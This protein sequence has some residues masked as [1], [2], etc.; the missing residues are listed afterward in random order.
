[1][2]NKLNTCKFYR[3]IKMENRSTTIIFLSL[4]LATL[5]MLGCS[6][7]KEQLG[8][9]KAAPDEFKV[10]RRAPLAMPPDYSLRPPQPGAP[11]PQESATVE[12]ARQTV[13]GAGTGGAVAAA[14]TSAG[15]ALLQRAGA[16]QADP[17]IR[18]KV[19]VEAKETADQNK[20]VIKKIMSIGRETEPSATVVDAPKEAERL[21]Q[22]ATKGNPPTAGETPSVEE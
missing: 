11:R 9:S 18:Q 10:V 12:Q 20:P 16:S 22:N 2:L 5:P 21:K 3:I 17:S 4:L 13:F 14:P 7:A 8:L 19:D 6:G 1:M 15:E